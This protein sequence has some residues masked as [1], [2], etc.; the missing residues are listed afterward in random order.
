MEGGK[1]VQSS[2][3][4]DVLD[5]LRQA[6]FWTLAPSLGTEG[7]WPTPITVNER[8]LRRQVEFGPMA[9]S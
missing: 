1:I 5:L 2:C 3:L 9:L 8:T 6:D 7:M 4:W